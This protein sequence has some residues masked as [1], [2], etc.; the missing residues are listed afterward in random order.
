MRGAGQ[1]QRVPSPIA[2]AVNLA[3]SAQLSSGGGARVDEVQLAGG[4]ATYPILN[5]GVYLC[6]LRFV[7]VKSL[8]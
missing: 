1:R 6:V 8:G 3:L 4:G 2:E 7:V 5:D